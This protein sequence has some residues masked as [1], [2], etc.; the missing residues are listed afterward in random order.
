MND[1]GKGSVLQGGP[2]KLLRSNGSRTI[3]AGGVILLAF[4]VIVLLGG[5]AAIPGPLASDP[6][7]YNPNTGYPAVG[8]GMV[9]Q[10]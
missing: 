9:W 8:S 10:Q 2:E 1:N 3:Q 4:A 7:Q 5:C 6:W